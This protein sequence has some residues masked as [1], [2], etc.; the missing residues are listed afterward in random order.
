MLKKGLL[1]PFHRGR[2]SQFSCAVTERD[3][4]TSAVYSDTCQFCLKFARDA[5]PGTK[6]KWTWLLQSFTSPSSSDFYTQHHNKSRSEIWANFPTASSREI[7]T[8]PDE[9]VKYANKSLTHFDSHEAFIL[10]SNRDTFKNFIV[11][12]LFDVDGALVPSKRARSLFVFKM[13]EDVLPQDNIVAY[14]VNI[15][16]VFMF[17]M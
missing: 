3:Q 14:S 10:T 12:L 11:H 9:A 6:R 5:K 2:R 16:S 17:K 8:Y 1:T 7:A 13:N 4:A 15:E